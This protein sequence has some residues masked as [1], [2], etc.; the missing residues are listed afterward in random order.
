MGRTQQVVL[1][2]STSSTIP[3]VSGSHKGQCCM[4]PLLFIIYINDLLEYIKHCSIR[5]FADDCVLYRLIFDH[6][7]T[8][9]VQE[10]LHTLQTWSQDWLM[11]FNAD[12]NA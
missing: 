10:D 7:D 12:L 4:G 6:N 3:V 9:L 5:L 8:T 11:N 1:G 2:G